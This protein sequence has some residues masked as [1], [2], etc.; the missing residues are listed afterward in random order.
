[1]TSRRCTFVEGGE[2][3]SLCTAEI[4]YK[5]WIDDCE[6][7]KAKALG[8]GIRYTGCGGHWA[9]IQHGAEVRAGELTKLDG[10]D[11]TVR[12]IRSAEAA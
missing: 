6:G 1:M 9:C 8:L 12:R 3:G 11:L 5:L 10:S 4:A 2:D 7:C